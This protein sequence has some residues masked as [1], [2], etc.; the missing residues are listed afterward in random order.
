MSAVKLGKCTYASSFT[1]EYG[2]ITL[3]IMKSGRLGLYYVDNINNEKTE[4]EEKTTI[5]ED[6]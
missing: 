5:Y 6:L 3:L 4:K 2:E 1:T